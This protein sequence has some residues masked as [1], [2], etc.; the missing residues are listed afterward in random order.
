MKLI[1]A[2][3]QR[4]RQFAGL[5]D[6]RLVES[7]YAMVNATIVKVHRHGLRAKADLAPDH[8][9]SRCGVMTMIWLTDALEFFCQAIASILSASSALRRSHLWRLHLR[10]AFDSTSLIAD[11][12]ERGAAI[13]ISQHPRG[14]SADAEPAKWLHLI[15]N[16]LACS[17]IHAPRHA[18]GQNRS[19]FAPIV[20]CS[21]MRGGPRRLGKAAGRLRK[22]PESSVPARR[23]RRRRIGHDQVDIEWD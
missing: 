8:C 19:D 1:G 11:L 2:G 13:V 9:C 5:H 3:H 7:S 17:K 14:T 18:R 16:F 10:E 21:E 20:G 12:N 4:L 22:P 15:E 6:L 23:Q